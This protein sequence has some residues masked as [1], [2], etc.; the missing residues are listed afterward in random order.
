MFQRFSWIAFL[1]MCVGNSGYAETV[2]LQ[3]YT[4]LS[5]NFIGCS[6]SISQTGIS[7]LFSPAAGLEERLLQIPATPAAANSTV[8]LEIKDG[9]GQPLQSLRVGKAVDVPEQIACTLRFDDVNF[10]GYRDIAVVIAFGAKWSQ[11]NYWVYDRKSDRYVT[12]AVTKA[13]GELTPTEIHFDNT[14]KTIKTRYL[15]INDGVS[16]ELFRIKGN[17]L[18]LMEKEI[19]HVEADP[20]KSTA[21]LYRRIHDK[22]RV[23]SQTI[24]Y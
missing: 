15:V 6:S 5:D 16:Y 14:T 8:F 3:A 9:T 13:L 19:L 23:V 10:D 2:T 11:S 21:T 20:E 18:V 1:G 24:I 12:T 4:Q 7:V 22:M 17:R